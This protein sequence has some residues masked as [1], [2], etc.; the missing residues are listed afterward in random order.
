MIMDFNAVFEV[1]HHFGGSFAPL[2]YLSGGNH[3]GRAGNTFYCENY[4]KS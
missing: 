1:K 4:R 2:A 3:N